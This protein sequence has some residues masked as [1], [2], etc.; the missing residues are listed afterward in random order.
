MVQGHVWPYHQQTQLESYSLSDAEPMQVV[1]QQRS[2]VIAAPRRVVQRLDRDTHPLH[3][4]LPPKVQKRYSTR[5]RGHCYQLP[6]NTTALD[7]SNFFYRLL[8]RDIYRLRLLID[9]C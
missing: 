5:P 4:L 7:E 6:R 1:T 8:Y 2:N 3:S 9:I